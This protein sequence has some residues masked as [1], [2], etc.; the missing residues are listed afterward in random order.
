MYD[1][2]SIKDAVMPA[3]FLWGSGYAGHQVEGNNINS[4]NWRAEQKRNQN[5]IS[6]L[7]G[8][9]CNSY[10]MYMDDVELVSKLGHQAFRTS[11]EW[12]RI[13]P[14]ENSF[15]EEAA[16]HYISFFAALKER[17][18]KV[19]CTMVHYSIPIWF[20]DKGGFYKEENLGYFEKYLDY[21][22]PK[23]AP[24][25]DF[26]NV[27]NE[28]NTSKKEEFKMN[29]LKFHALGYHTIKKY[30]S[31]PVSSAH[32]F[33]NYMPYRPNNKM[34][35]ASAQ[36]RDANDNE[37][38]FHAMRTGE[39]IQIGRDGFYSEDIKNTVD[40]WS[41]NIYTRTLTNSM[42]KA[43]KSD[44]YHKKLRMIDMDFYL[45]ELYP[46]CMINT[47]T[48]LTDKPVYI[49]E[50]GCCC[51]D[52]RFRIVYMILHF[53]ALRQCIDMGVDVK[54][55]LY[56]SLLDNYEWWSYRPKFGL[57]SVDR[58]SGT[59]NRTPKP[60]AWMYKEIIENNGFNQKIIRK[61]IKELPS[62]GL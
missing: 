52:D 22:V 50:N 26:Y 42:D 29:S 43:G 45:D 54:G 13:Q 11:V 15:S 20:E 33:V 46:E 14:D 37:F 57:C 3:G 7:S 32:A 18:I 31:A 55:F 27:L 19:F 53:S 47:L 10:E 25:V 8:I 56:W 24:Y 36:Y 35:I 49:T 4:S 41:I 60:S 17:G 59:F 1:I 61:Y 23:I 58:E 28:F 62:L 21:I 6:E 44:Y 51:N 34:D 5:P 40:F 48:R 12:S 9:A 30:T 38:F 16:E 2:F 39:V